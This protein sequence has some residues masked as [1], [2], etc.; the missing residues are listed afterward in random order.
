MWPVSHPSARTLPSLRSSSWRPSSSDVFVSSALIVSLFLIP[1]SPFY[2]SSFFYLYN[3][4]S[5]FH[6]LSNFLFLIFISYA[7][8]SH[9]LSLFFLILSYS[10]SFSYSSISHFLSHFPFILKYP[11]S[12]SPLSY[13]KTNYFPKYFPN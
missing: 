11:M 4:H 10:S 6:F 7:I 8:N 9:T 5:Y 1:H 2:F 3:S 13:H 12:L